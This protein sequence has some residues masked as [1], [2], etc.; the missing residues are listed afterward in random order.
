MKGHK[1]NLRDFIEDA[2]FIHIL[3]TFVL[4]GTAYM[5][6]KWEPSLRCL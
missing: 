3:K 1:I 2:P 6:S 5:M 4:R